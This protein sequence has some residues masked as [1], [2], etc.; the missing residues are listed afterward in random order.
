[1]VSI[2]KGTEKARAISRPGVLNFSFLVVNHLTDKSLRPFSS[3][4]NHRLLRNG[5]CDICA[6]CNEPCVKKQYFHAARRDD[7][8]VRGFV[9]PRRARHGVRE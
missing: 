8:P 3:I 6:H 5:G 7:K 9:F 4:A 2:G 1:M